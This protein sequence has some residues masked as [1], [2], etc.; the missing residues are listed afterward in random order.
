MVLHASVMSI[1][2]QI[3]HFYCVRYQVYYYPRNGS[4]PRV[5][6]N[7]DIQ[8]SSMEYLLSITLSHNTLSGCTS[9]LLVLTNVV[10]ASKKWNSFQHFTV[11]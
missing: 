8:H 10:K 4:I 6:I 2:K 3:L 11:L 1:I 9:C 5:V 7:L